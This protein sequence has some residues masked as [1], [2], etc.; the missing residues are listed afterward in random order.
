MTILAIDPGPEKSAYVLARPRYS[1]S[2]D[3]TPYPLEIDD[4]GILDN[5]AILTVVHDHARGEDPYLVI[6]QIA[7]MGMAVGE[8]TFETCVWTGRFLERFDRY[9]SGS[10]RLKRVPIKV[11]LCGTAKAKDANVRQSLIDRFGGSWAIAKGKSGTKSRE[12]VQ[13]GPLAGISSHVWSALAVA[14]VF[15]DK[16]KIGEMK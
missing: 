9:S 15:L 1:G 10:Y 14:V 3:K 8:E 13:A 11:H 16:Y 12:P 2:L 6:E 4:F 5:A 7:S